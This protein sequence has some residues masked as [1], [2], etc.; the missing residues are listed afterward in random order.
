M[1]QSN[2]TNLY[3][4][5]TR[6]TKLK[7][8]AWHRFKFTSYTEREFFGKVEAYNEAIQLVNFYLPKAVSKK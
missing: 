2:Q 8:E 7:N 3:V 1:Q 6:L 4:L 5:R